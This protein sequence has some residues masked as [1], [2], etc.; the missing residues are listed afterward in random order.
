MERLQA[1]LEASVYV[2][3]ILH[4]AHNTYEVF[5][6]AYNRLLDSLGQ[7]IDTTKEDVKNM[8]QQMSIKTGIE[9]PGIPSSK[10]SLAPHVED[11]PKVQY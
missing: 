7:K 5:R 8:I 2:F 11:Y 3:T 1:R 4:Y 10:I 6:D 9:I